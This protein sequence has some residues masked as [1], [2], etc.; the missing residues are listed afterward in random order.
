ML[1]RV[2]VCAWIVATIWAVYA[3][4]ALYEELWTGFVIAL[5]GLIA[6]LFIVGAFHSRSHKRSYPDKRQLHN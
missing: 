5:T 2:L 6:T 3:A 4:I 1:N